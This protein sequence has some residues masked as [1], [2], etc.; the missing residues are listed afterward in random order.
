MPAFSAAVLLYEQPG[1]MIEP[2]GDVN[3]NGEFDMADVIQM[4]RDL[5]AGASDPCL[6]FNS[7]GK[8]N[9]T[10]V[11]AALVELAKTS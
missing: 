5:V 8:Q 3:G 7:D 11:V 2:K 1:C 10:D 9:I 6:D 4:I